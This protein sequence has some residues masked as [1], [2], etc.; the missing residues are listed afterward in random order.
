MKLLGLNTVRFI[1]FFVL[2]TLHY[3]GLHKLGNEVVSLFFTLSSF[4]LT[5][6]MFAEL[7]QKGRFSAKNFFFRRALRIF[8]LYFT[9]LA[10]SFVVLPLLAETSNYSVTLPEKSWYYWLFI[11]NYEKSDHIFALKFLWTIS[12]EEQFYLLFIFVSFFFRRYFLIV[13]VS[14]AVVYLIYSCFVYGAKNQ[15]FGIIFSYFPFFISGMLAAY[16]FSFKKLEINQVVLV[17]V[18]GVF[19]SLILQQY[20]W[21]YFIALA[22]TNGALLIVI[23][24]LVQK[25]RSIQQFNGFRILEK[26]GEYTFGLYVFSGF[27]LTFGK[28]IFPKINTF[29]LFLSELI[30][31]GIL[32]YFSYN[33]F[34]KKL[35]LLKKY[36]R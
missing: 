24:L 30:L 3:F 11:G 10:F 22:I 8:P 18:T 1:G 34:E 2:F 32:A 35:L 12:V 6:L 36:F 21:L 25:Y 5:Y 31:V 15:P 20:E 9:V 17:F 19:L 7:N 27:V 26:A 33:L 4:L 13:I 14:L 29:L 28:L 16:M 23:I